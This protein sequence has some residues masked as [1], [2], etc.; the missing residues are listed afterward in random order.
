MKTTIGLLL[1]LVGATV[2]V[3]AQMAPSQARS[4]ELAEGRDMAR[5]IPAV[6]VIEAVDAEA[7]RVRINGQWYRMVSNGSQYARADNQALSVQD[8][9]PGMEV[10]MQTD[11]TEP[12]RGNEPLIL[13]IWSQ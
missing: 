1:I 6:A 10:M 3:Q 4:V 12:S 9:L 7:M 8:L 2:A 13:S 11:G 5:S